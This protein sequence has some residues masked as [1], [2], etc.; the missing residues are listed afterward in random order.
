[1][2]RYAEEKATN[3]FTAKDSCHSSTPCDGIRSESELTSGVRY[4]RTT[5]Q[6]CWDPWDG[7]AAA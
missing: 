3:P 6:E 7:V 4:H 5:G 1:M 2:E